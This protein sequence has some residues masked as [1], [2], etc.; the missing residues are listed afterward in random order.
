M[1]AAAAGAPAAWPECAAKSVCAMRI[2]TTLLLTPSYTNAVAGATALNV[3]GGMSGFAAAL[4]PE[5]AL[6]GFEAQ[7]DAIEEALGSLVGGGFKCD[8]LME[9]S[10]NAGRSRATISGSMPAAIRSTLRS[11]SPAAPCSRACAR[12]R[13]R[14]SVSRSR[15]TASPP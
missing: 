6:A 5:L 8:G 13:T 1:G 2:A 15:H 7:D 3:A 12:R 4:A 14:S 9:G 10:A 11:N